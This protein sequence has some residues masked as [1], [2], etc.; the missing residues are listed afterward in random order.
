MKRS[1]YKKSNK[2]KNKSIN[3]KLKL[4]LY[5][6]LFILLL[7]V[8]FLFLNNSNIIFSSGFLLNFKSID[9]LSISLAVRSYHEI[10]NYLSNKFNN[11]NKYKLI[12]NEKLLPFKEKEPKNQEKKVI[13]IYGRG[14][15]QRWKTIIEENVKDKYIVEYDRDNP[16]YLFYTTFSCNFLKSKYNN[17][18]KIAYFAENQLPDFRMTDYAISNSHFNYLDRHIYAPSIYR[19]L[20]YKNVSYDDFKK[21]RKNALN[22]PKRTKFC[23]TVISNIEGKRINFIE[24]INK[25]KNIDQGGSYNNNIGGKVKDKIEFLTLYKFS[26][27]MENSENNGYITEK[28]MD[29]FLGGTIPIYYGGYMADEFFNPKS[30]ILIRGENDLNKKIEYIKLID[31]DDELYR[32]ILKEEVLLDKNIIEGYA[33]EQKEFFLNIFD[34]DK[35]KARRIERNFHFR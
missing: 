1:K 3:I 17:S 24:E 23:A 14:M 34:Q 8:I 7:N 4:Y 10:A 33:K 2:K 15:H 35:K 25:Y 30:F 27:A 11:N 29:S 21:A 31:N 5:I 6:N 16:D 28:L 13:K 19:N 12:E 18:I 9:Y 20:F 26:I 32:S 22:G